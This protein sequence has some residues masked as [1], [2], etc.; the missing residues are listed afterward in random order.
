MCQLRVGKSHGQCQNDDQ[1]DEVHRISQVSY[2]RHTQRLG[3]HTCDAGE[4]NVH[5]EDPV[6]EGASVAARR[7]HDA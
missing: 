3:G 1:M 5:Q 7:I 6:E 4:Q 2:V